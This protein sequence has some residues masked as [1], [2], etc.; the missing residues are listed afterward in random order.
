MIK[1]NDVTITYTGD[2]P[3]EVE[4]ARSLFLRLI[5]QSKPVTTLAYVMEVSGTEPT[6]K[7]RFVGA[8]KVQE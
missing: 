4:N 7:L 6:V 1:L 5:R 3:E 2:T 8:P